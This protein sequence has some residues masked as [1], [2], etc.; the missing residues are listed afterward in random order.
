M[1]HYKSE[2]ENSIPYL[3]VP[4]ILSTTE[5]AFGIAAFLPTGS[6]HS[7]RS[8][9]SQQELS[10]LFNSLMSRV[11]APKLEHLL[12]QSLIQHFLFYLFYY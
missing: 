3:P 7:Q 5:M 1:R 2:S 8:E 6:A 4:I 11:Y 9:L 12:I 10:S